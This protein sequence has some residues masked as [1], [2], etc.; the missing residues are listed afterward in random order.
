MKELPRKKLCYLVTRYG[1]SV[2]DDSLS[3]EGLL[4]DVCGEYHREVF[5]LVCA[6]KEQIPSELLRSHDNIPHSM[7]MMKL[8]KRL[9]NNLALT[10]N[11]AKW[12]VESWALA[13]GIITYNDIK[14][15]NIQKQKVNV[16][17]RTKSSSW[18]GLMWGGNSKVMF[19]RIVL[20]SPKPFRKMT[21]KNLMINI[22]RK[23][24][25]SGKVTEN[26]IIECIKE[27]TPKPFVEEA[28]KSIESLR[29]TTL[30]LKLVRK[31]S[32]P[33]SGMVIT[34]LI[35][36]IQEKIRSCFINFFKIVDK[37]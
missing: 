36:K 24:E 30:D 14:M 21:E 1:R 10:K 17:Y 25:T 6:L 2:C 37:L 5:V 19:D 8:T 31:H 34:E 28:L 18:R 35:K 26:T 27:I 16:V 13:L 32:S 4:R 9:S 7:L 3:C 11:A 29:T 20:S 23:V 12:A 22:C 15:K 33:K